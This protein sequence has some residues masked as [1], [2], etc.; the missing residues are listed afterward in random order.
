MPAKTSGTDKPQAHTGERHPEQ[1]RRDLNPNAMAGQNLGAAGPHPEK[2]GPTAYDFKPLHHSLRDFADD[3]LKRIRILPAGTRLEQGATYFDLKN[4]SRGEF[5]ATGGMEVG[6]E[7]WCVAK[8]EV[9]YHLWNR[10]I[11][12][13]N[14]ERLG[15]GNLP[16]HG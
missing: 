9:D 3:E 1:W 8:S 11:G 7:D 4:P 12:V 2:Q 5:T 16:R 13:T 15:T 14:P 6:P 10:L